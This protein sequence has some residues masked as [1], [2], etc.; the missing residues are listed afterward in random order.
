MPF[1]PWLHVR[2][3]V[4]Y[5]IKMCC[6][7]KRLRSGGGRLIERMERKEAQKK[8]KNLAREEVDLIALYCPLTTTDNSGRN[9]IK[10][11][12]FTLFDI[13]FNAGF[14]PLKRRLSQ[15]C[16]FTATCGDKEWVGV[17]IGHITTAQ[18]ISWRCFKW[19]HMSVWRVTFF[20]G[21]PEKMINVLASEKSLGEGRQINLPWTYEL[22][23]WLSPC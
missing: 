9:M 10:S 17:W 2:L 6:L 8:E 22:C 4:S 21:V 19:T 11:L 16:V 20:R 14:V 23:M 13:Y 12:L 5:C 3:L 18:C 1:S 7:R 15:A